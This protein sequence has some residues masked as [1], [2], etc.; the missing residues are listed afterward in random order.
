MFKHAEFAD[1]DPKARRWYRRAFQTGTQAVSLYDL[2]IARGL[3]LAL[4]TDGIINL[5]TLDKMFKRILDG[6][7]KSLVR[8]VPMKDRAILGKG[9]SAP[10]S[11]STRRKRR[12]R[13]AA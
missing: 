3:L 1:Q 11:K 12:S 8:Q 7:P 9:R 13:P 5:S 10:A 6:T 2:G 4:K